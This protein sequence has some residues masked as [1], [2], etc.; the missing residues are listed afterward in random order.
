MEYRAKLVPNE[1]IG[2]NEYNIAVSSY[3]QQKDTREKID[4][5]ELNQQIAGIVER[6]QQ[7]RTQID[8]IVADLEGA[9]R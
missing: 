1:Q 2:D 9:R 5:H 3:V 6:E 4:I 7:L 8:E